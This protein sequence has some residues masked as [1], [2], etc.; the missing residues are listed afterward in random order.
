[1]VVYVNGDSHAAAAEAA[2]P[3]SMAKDDVAHWALGRRSHPVN[4]QVSFGYLISQQ[5]KSD[6]CCDAE[7]GSSNLRILR[8]TREWL[9]RNTAPD[10]LLIIQWSTWERDEWIINGEYYQVGASGTDTVPDAYQDRYRYFILDMNWHERRRQWHQDIWHFHC[11][12]QYQ[13]IRHVFFNGNNHFE[14]EP[15]LD[16][17]NHYISP[18][19]G[20]GTYDSLL[21]INGYETVN[22]DSWHFGA[23]AHC[24]WAN[25]VLQ[26]IHD[27]KL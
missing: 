9:A 19:D 3:W 26:Y 14:G 12:L 13:G 11:E 2:G 25:Y 21:R 4:Q 8:S 23:D 20:M 24:F 7:S 27:H 15:R 22:T 17:K 16:W 1:M 10:P 18:Y 5:L 6:Y